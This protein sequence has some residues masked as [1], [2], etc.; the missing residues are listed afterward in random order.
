MQKK[1]NNAEPLLARA[2]G[3]LT[4]AYGPAHPGVA[5]ALAN[6]AEQYMLRRKFELAEDAYR[7]ALDIRHKVFGSEH[8][9]VALISSRLAAALIQRGALEE[10]RE[11]FLFAL[12]IQERILGSNSSELA[13]TLEHFAMLLR[14]TDD[15]VQAESIE[16]RAGAI[17]GVLAYTT[18]ADRLVP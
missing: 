11:L 9:G 5:D 18:S 10:A 14:K 1:W 2:I 3:L 15:V 8:I 13:S 17:R 12:P 16:A 4:S 6:L 7:R